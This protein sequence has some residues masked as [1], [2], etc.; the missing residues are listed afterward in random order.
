MRSGSILAII[1]ARGG[2]KRLPR[3]NIL[4]VAGR[5]LISYTIEAARGAGLVDRFVVNTEDAE[6]KAIARQWGAEV[7]DRPA[8]LAGDTVR[9]NEV[10]DHMLD[11]IEAVGELPDFIVLLQATSP[12]RT[13]AQIDACIAAFLEGNHASATS[14]AEVEHHPYKSMVIRDGALEALIDRESLEMPHQKLPLVYRPNGAVYIVETRRFRES[15]L[16][17]APP[18]QPFIMDAISSIDVDGEIDL[19]LVEREIERRLAE[20]G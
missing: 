20:T 15:G 8:S 19:F 14:V 6:I 11:E 13:A 17:S 7:V 4:P 5:P 3:K 18:V 16:F 1:P 9:T 2:S 12:L 10:V